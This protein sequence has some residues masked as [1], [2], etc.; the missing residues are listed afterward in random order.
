MW[1][2]PRPA[3]PASRGAITGNGQQLRLNW[4][5]YREISMRS[6]IKNFYRTIG[7]KK[8]TCDVALFVLQFLMCD[9]G[10]NL[11]LQHRDLVHNNIPEDLQVNTEIPV[12]QG[13]A[14]PGNGFPVSDR[15]LCLQIIA[16]VLDSF[17]DDLKIAY[18]RIDPH[19]IVPELIKCQVTNIRPDI[20]CR[21]RNIVEIE[22]L[23]P[24]HRQR[25]AGWDHG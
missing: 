13:I 5:C 24:R 22:Q 9:N 8:G 6:A 2:E 15:E 23:G 21:L 16:Q 12:D 20:S 25:P 19:P 17:P 18:N 3:T 14:E 10:G 11:F 1:V 4:E 7:R